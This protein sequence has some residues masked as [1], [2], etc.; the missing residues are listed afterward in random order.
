MLIRGW[1]GMVAESNARK[2]LLVMTNT[3]FLCIVAALLLRIDFS[4]LKGQL[5]TLGWGSR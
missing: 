4:G 2:V 1:G 3:E 5:R